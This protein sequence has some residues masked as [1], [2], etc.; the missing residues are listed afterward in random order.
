M[1]KAFLRTD[2]GRM[3]F[4][5]RGEGHR[6]LL[7]HGIPTSSF[8]WRNVIPPL[9]EALKVYAVDLL[10]Y[11]DSDK[12]EGADLS[13]V[14][15]ANYLRAFM[16]EVGW[17]RGAVAGH[18]IGGGIA[19][20][21]ALE[22]PQAI[23]NLVLLDTI[24]YDSWPVSE[25]ERLKDPAWDEILATRDLSSG[26]AKSFKRGMVREERVDD[27][28]VAEYVRPFEG[29]EGRRAYLRCARALR[30]EDLASVMDRVE[31]LDVPTLIIWGE[32]DDFQKVEYGRRLAAAMPRARLV[33]LEEAG[34]FVPEDRPEE[35]AR[36]IREFVRADP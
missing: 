6:I 28:L 1:D 33:V 10:G 16:R 27:Q 9:A 19:Q 17:D 3:A 11:G 18:D 24:A 26:F 35:V 30:T 22:S 4:V 2:A 36:L 5:E 29:V 12:P 15:Q 21:L 20:L 34:H 25:I 31:L 13:I 7:I 8:L 32:G 23:T 14:A